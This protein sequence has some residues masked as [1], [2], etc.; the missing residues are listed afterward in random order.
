[1]LNG[2]NLVADDDFPVNWSVI[3]Y[4]VETLKYLITFVV[5]IRVVQ[6]FFPR[7]KKSFTVVPSGQETLND[8]IF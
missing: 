4:L 7:A 6:Y 8:T 1:M 3:L 2:M 5:Y